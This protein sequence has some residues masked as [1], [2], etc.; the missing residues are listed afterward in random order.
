MGYITSIFYPMHLNKKM[1]KIYLS[2]QIL[3]FL[4][5]FISKTK[6][7]QGFYLLYK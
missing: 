2:I 1:I 3:S 5:S 7:N 4:F 6:N